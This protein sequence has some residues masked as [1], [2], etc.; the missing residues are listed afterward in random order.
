[1]RA[2]LQGVDVH[3][4]L[5]RFMRLDF[6]FLRER[7]LGEAMRLFARFG[8]TMVPVVDAGF[9]LRDVVTLRDVLSEARIR[10]SDETC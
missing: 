9:R 2:L 6:K 3:A 4:P 10:N 8:I 7:D 1:M 5:E